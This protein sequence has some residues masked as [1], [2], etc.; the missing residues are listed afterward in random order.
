MKSTWLFPY[1]YTR[2]DAQSWIDTTKTDKMFVNSYAVTN[3]D[4][5]IGAV[6]LIMHDS[7]K[8]SCIEIGIG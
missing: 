3:L 5:Y 4:K 2:E 8:Y 1:P 6:G 7:E